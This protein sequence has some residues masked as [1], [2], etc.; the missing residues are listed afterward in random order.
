MERKTISDI[1]FS[2]RSILNADCFLVNKFYAWVSGSNL[3]VHFIDWLS[4]PIS[5]SEF[6]EGITWQDI[7]DYAEGVPFSNS[8]LSGTLGEMLKISRMETAERLFDK[9]L[10]EGL[11]EKTISLV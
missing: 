8:S 1:H 6:P 2:L 5:K 11:D 4:S 3:N 10:H 7:I 9:F